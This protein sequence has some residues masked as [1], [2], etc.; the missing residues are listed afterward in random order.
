MI[1]VVDAAVEK[2]LRRQA[3]RFLM[4]FSP[5]RRPLRFTIKNLRCAE[6]TLHAVK[7]YVVSIKGP[8][9]TPVGGGIR[10]LTWLCVKQA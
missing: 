4:E 3:A 8:L 9:T 1:K 10:S 2:A 6:E 7:E 5:A